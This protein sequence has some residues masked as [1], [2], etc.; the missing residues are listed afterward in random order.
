MKE[1]QGPGLPKFTSPIQRNRTTEAASGAPGEAF[2]SSDPTPPWLQKPQFEGNGDPPQEKKGWGT[3]KT[4]A[5]MGLGVIAGGG[6]AVGIMQAN[7]P[8]QVQVQLSE[9]QAERAQA[10]FQ[11]LQEVGGTLKGEPQNLVQKVVGYHPT[12]NAQE[13]VKGLSYG[14]S[15]AWYPTPDSQPVQIRSVDQLRDV[16]NQVRVEMLKQGIQQ[17]AANFGELLQ[18]LGKDLGDVFKQ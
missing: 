6:L 16:S 3:G 10:N 15:V 14:Q 12:V 13:A 7:Q 11:Y 5:V 8:P 2:T 9:R 1:I 18:Q 17:G 4:L